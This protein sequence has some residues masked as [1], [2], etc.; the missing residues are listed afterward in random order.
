MQKIAECTK[1]ASIISVHAVHL[2]KIA[3]AECRACTYSTS[4]SCQVILSNLFSHKAT[5][6]YK[7]VSTFG[8]F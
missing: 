3:G 8:L 5:F 7:F 6:L 2:M 4:I 1:W